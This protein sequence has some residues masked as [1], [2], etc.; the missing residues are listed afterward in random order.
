M[1]TVVV[2]VSWAAGVPVRTLDHGFWLALGG[3]A[4]PAAP[5]YGRMK[6]WM[7]APGTLAAVETENGLLVEIR[8]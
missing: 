1:L 4:R 6:G 3:A 2:L 8:S 7:I 5:R